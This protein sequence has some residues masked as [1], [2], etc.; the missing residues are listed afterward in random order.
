MKRSEGG[1]S[2]EGFREILTTKGVSIWEMD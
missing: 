2:V 1:I